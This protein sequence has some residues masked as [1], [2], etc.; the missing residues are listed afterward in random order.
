MSMNEKIITRRYIFSQAELKK[1]LELEG[2]TIRN[3]GLWSGRSPNDE[4][5]GVS[6]DTDTYFIET[7]EKHL[8]PTVDVEKSR[9][10]LIKLQEKTDEEKE[11][12]NFS[13]SIYGDR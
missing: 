13:L 7:E 2:D 9:I 1:K 5:E 4:E 6:P 8:Y 12:D 11:L 3:I 10:K